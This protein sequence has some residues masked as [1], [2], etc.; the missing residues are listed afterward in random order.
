MSFNRFIDTF[1]TNYECYSSSILLEYFAPDNKDFIDV[2]TKTI[3]NF[4]NYILYHDVVPEYESSIFAARNVCDLASKELW[5]TCQA[6]SGAP[7]DF[8]MACST[9]FGDEWSG[10]YSGDQEWAKEETEMVGMPGDTARKVVKSAIAG[11][12]TLEQADRFRGLANE[13]KLEAKCVEENGFEV[14]SIIPAT[15]DVK[16]FYREYA[17]DLKP[18]GKIRARPWR[19]P[20]DGE[21]DFP[22]GEVSSYLKNHGMEYEFFIEERYLDCFFEGMKFEAKIWELNCGIYFFEKVLAIFCSFYTVLP[23]ESMLGWK[24]PRDLK[25]DELAFA[26]GANGRNKEADAN[27]EVVGESEGEDNQATD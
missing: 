4:L 5:L 8:N 11:A 12:G 25:D 2:A 15:N 20:G 10:M 3:K 6:S 27:G 7:G 13:N 19:N 24:K 17:K 18:V 1:T 21:E 26:E 23:N 16:V 14:I 22:P 9:L